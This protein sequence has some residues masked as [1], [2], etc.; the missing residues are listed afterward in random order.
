MFALALA[1]DELPDTDALDVL[2]PS[3]DGGPVP[4]YL[5]GD[6]IDTDG[7]LIHPPGMLID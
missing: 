5:G 4:P 2:K 6:V 1:A 7:T 3:I